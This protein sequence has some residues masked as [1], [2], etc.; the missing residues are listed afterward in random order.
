[1]SRRLA[2]GASLLMTRRCFIGL[3]GALL[4]AGPAL[5]VWAASNEDSAACNQ[6]DLGACTRIIDDALAAA[7]DRVTASIKRGLYHRDHGD[8]NLAL[9]DFRQAVSL[10]PTNSSA[11]L[12]NR[13]LAVAGDD[14]RDLQVLSYAIADSASPAEK[15]AI[16][17]CGQE[18]SRKRSGLTCAVVELACDGLA[19]L[20]AALRPDQSRPCAVGDKVTVSG[21]IQDVARKRGAWSAGT[22]ATVDNCRGLV[23]PST[24]FA[25]LFG[26]GRPPS[27]C[28]KGRRFLAVGITGYGFDP[29]FFLN[30]Q[31]IKCE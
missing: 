6:G 31:S 25:A 9:A 13:C 22:L 7:H 12:S 4:A 20:P 17:R 16:D 14:D 23:D 2:S 26:H 18:A 29:Q 28:I 11:S 19:A 10:D 5:P 27:E 30:V 3:I 21:T 8:R 15:A 1:M 24:G